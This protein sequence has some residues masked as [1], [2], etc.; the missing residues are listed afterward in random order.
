VL[1]VEPHFLT[2]Q[3]LKRSLIE[4]KIMLQIVRS[5]SVFSENVSR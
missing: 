4:D 2:E 1:G 5:L 3:A